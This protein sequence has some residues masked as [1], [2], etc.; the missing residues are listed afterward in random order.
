LNPDCI[1]AADSTGTSAAWADV[2]KKATTITHAAR[3]VTASVRRRLGSMD[4]SIAA[5]QLWT[6]GDLCHRAKSPRPDEAG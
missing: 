2:E 4:F 1:A 3:A 5:R 6:C